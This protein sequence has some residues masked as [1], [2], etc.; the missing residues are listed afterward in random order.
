MNDRYLKWMDASHAFKAHGPG[1]LAPV[2]Q[3]GRIANVAKDGVDSLHVGGMGCVNDAHTGVE[4]FGSSRSFG[5]AKVGSVVL[6]ADGQGDDAIGSGGDSE[7]VLDTERGF[8]DRH[9]PD[10]S[11]DMVSSD[12]RLDGS[13]NVRHLLRRFYLGNEN[14]VGR[15]RHNLF[16]I[17]KAQGQLIDAHHAL[18][19]AEVNRTKSVAHQQTGSILLGVVNGILEIED[20]RVR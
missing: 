17:G 4:R 5:D 10:G 19:R 2:Q 14:E 6:Q 13:H 12:D 11:C 9:K 8:Q 16:Q 20:D 18:G 1:C 3:T 15:L 7:G